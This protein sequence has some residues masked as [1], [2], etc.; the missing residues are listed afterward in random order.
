MLQSEK[1][2]RRLSD[3]LKTEAFIRGGVKRNGHLFEV[4][5]YSTIVNT[6]RTRLEMKVVSNRAFSSMLRREKFLS[7]D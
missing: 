5:R 3:R 6:K 1:C 4:L 2:L 7:Q